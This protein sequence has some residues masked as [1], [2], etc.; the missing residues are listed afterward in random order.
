MTAWWKSCLI[1]LA[2]EAI[3][4]RVQVVVEIA[5]ELEIWKGG[6]CQTFPSV[7]RTLSPGLWLLF[8]S[9]YSSAY[10]KPACSSSPSLPSTPMELLQSNTLTAEIF[11]HSAQM[12]FLNPGFLFPLWI[13]GI[14]PA[15]YL[16]FWP[17]SNFSES[18]SLAIFPKWLYLLFWTV[19][20]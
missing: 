7:H 14:T 18:A 1:H 2:N 4:K 17:H 12:E 20:L 11:W 9:L 8:L 13:F 10:W 15:F 5:P 6:K 19:S 16:G 3:G